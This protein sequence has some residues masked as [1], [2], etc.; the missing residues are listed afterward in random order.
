VAFVALHQ[1][2]IVAVIVGTARFHNIVPIDIETE[3]QHRKKG[4]ASALTQCFVNEFVDNHL[5]A[6]WDCVDSNIASKK[7]AQKTEF[8]IMS[9]FLS[10]V[11]HLFI[12]EKIIFK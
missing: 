10:N 4:L 8:M 2:R 5:V 1:T 7:T 3:E 12:D 6:Q 9:Q 11:L